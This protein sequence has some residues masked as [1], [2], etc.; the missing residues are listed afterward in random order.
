MTREPATPAEEQMSDEL[1]PCPFCGGKAV[2]TNVRMSGREFKVGCYNDLCWRPGT[3]YYDRSDHA[4][5][6]W[7]TRA[8]LTARADGEAVAWAT[9][10]I[11]EHLRQGNPATVGP[12]PG[13]DFNI[14]LYTHPSPA[15]EADAPAPGPAGESE[16]EV[17]TVRQIAVGINHALM[18]L[19]LP[20]SGQ[21][22]RAWTS[23]IE[24]RDKAEALEAAQRARK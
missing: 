13:A 20:T 23:L 6:A 8:Q 9:D 7:N 22:K 24:A 17:N 1:K 2:L 4:V 5:A 3:D 21:G 10:G 19:E 15:L 11:I 16:A 14:P 12:R 18:V